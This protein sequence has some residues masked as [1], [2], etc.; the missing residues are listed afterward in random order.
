MKKL[1][2]I[3]IIFFIVL[4]GL[5]IRCAPN[6][7]YK[8]SGTSISKGSPGNGSL[9]NAY[10]IDL[11]DDFYKTKSGQEVKKRGIYFARHLPKK[12]DIMHDDHYH[13]D[14]KIKN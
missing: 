4:I 6:I 11:K 9:E 1:K 5:M 14:F 13:I 8:N 7:F 2:I 12:V 10:Q 3:L